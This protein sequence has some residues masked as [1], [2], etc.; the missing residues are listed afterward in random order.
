MAI[1]WRDYRDEDPL[2]PELDYIIPRRGRARRTV[3]A[4]VTGLLAVE[5][6]GREHHNEAT[7]L[8]ERMTA[9]SSI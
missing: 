2:P 4:V 8:E 7:R 9:H 6:L 1:W 5:Q 3:E